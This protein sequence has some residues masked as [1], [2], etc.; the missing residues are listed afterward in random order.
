MAKLPLSK[1]NSGFVFCIP[2]NSSDSFNA[3]V[4]KAA[5]NRRCNSKMTAKNKSGVE[6]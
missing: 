1:L 5:I 6:R 2:L 4:L 3:P